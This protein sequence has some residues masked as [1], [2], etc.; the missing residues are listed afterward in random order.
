MGKTMS[1]VDSMQWYVMFPCYHS[2]RHAPWLL[3][4]LLRI[5]QPVRRVVD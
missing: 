4:G 2:H 5:W 1:I 3:N